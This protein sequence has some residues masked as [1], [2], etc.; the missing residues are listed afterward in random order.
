MVDQYGFTPGG[1]TW[2]IGTTTLRFLC[3]RLGLK[4]PL[5]LRGESLIAEPA[6]L[7][8]LFQSD[9]QNHWAELTERLSNLFVSQPVTAYGPNTC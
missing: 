8:A 4:Q 6:G 5:R 3:H 2:I 1:G 9:R 7:E